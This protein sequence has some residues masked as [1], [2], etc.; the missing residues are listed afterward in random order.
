ME[1]NESNTEISTILLNEI[2]QDYKKTKKRQR[3]Y[4]YFYYGI[5]FLFI[6]YIAMAA[7]TVQSALNKKNAEP[8]PLPEKYVAA[9]KIEGALIQHADGCDFKKVNE[10]IERAF[11]D[12]HSV[13]VL[14]DLDSPGGSVY[15]SYEVYAKIMQM[16]K[17]YPE[18][19]V[20]S[21]VRG[22]A[23]SGAYLVACATDE[24]YASNRF[25]NVGSIGVYIGTFNL[26]NFLKEHKIDPIF[27][28]SGRNKG[29]FNMIQEVSPE[30]V[31]EAQKG[32]DVV[33][34][35]FIDIV[36]LSRGERLKANDRTFSGLAFMGSD[37][38][39]QGLIDGYDV[40][41]ESV[42]TDKIGDYTIQYIRP[43]KKNLDA[44]FEDL[45]DRYSVL[46]AKSFYHTMVREHDASAQQVQAYAS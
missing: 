32:I 40:T 44:F 9:V 41:L 39:N 26:H 13:A 3:L 33:Y 36:K 46:A 34:E 23:A 45:V 38:Y 17:K 28:K 42:I 21:Y 35:D 22:V 10:M 2:Y 1:K 24:I 27:I 43:A 29:S 7:S 25:S 14:L 11:D 15:D 8:Q 5:F 37:G 6:M 16:R 30:M 18:K 31:Q 12:E 4:S 20:I 19:K